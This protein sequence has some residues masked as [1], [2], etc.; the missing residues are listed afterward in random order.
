MTD[1][2]TLIDA[3]ITTLLGMRDAKLSELATIDGALQAFQY[4]REMAVA[5]VAPV[6]PAT[7][8]AS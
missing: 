1:P 2:L 5:P 3:E 6:A 4:L 7:A 8:V